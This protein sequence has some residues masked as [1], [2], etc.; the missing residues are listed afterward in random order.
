MNLLGDQ[1]AATVSGGRR[2]VADFVANIEHLIGDVGNGHAKR[3]VHCD[4]L[5]FLVRR[6]AEIESR[7][8]A[9]R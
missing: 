1:I 9:R 6:L 3:R 2:S 4:D 8:S 7:T 5:F